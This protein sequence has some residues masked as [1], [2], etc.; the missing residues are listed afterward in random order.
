MKHVYSAMWNLGNITVISAESNLGESSSNSGLVSS[1]HF[2]TIAHENIN[3]F[4][5]PGHHI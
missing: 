2:C 3:L 1:V 4:L 5:L